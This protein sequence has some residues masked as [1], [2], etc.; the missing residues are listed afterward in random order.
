MRTN[1]LNRVDISPSDITE[2]LRTPSNFGYSGDLPIGETWA[3]GPVIR[4][5]ESK[6]LE[7]SNADALIAHLESLVS[8]GVILEDDYQVTTCGHW[9]VGWVEH[10]SF[11]A[12]EANGEPTN[13]FRALKAWDAALSDYPVADD[14]DYSRR[15]YETQLDSI[16]DEVRKLLKSDALE[17]YSGDVF[18]YLW[19]NQSEG[20]R[21]TDKEWQ[22]VRRAFEDPEAWSFPKAPIVEAMRELDLLDPDHC[23]C[24]GEYLG[25]GEDDRAGEITA[26][27]GKAWATCK[28]CTEE[29]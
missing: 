9:A 27:N 12:I 13:V 28:D 5:R 26:D 22:G 15:Q 14:E 20:W 18:G 8:E 1:D 23:A 11:R 17:G 21:Y 7:E 2:A 10:L 6:I 4:H 16:A 25:P 29:G 19:D 3:L 24:C